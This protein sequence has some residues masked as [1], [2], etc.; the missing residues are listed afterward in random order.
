MPD[1]HRRRA[2]MHSFEQSPEGSKLPRYAIYDLLH[3]PL[4]E[5]P[6]TP[7]S[8]SLFW[9]D[10]QPQLRSCR[11]SSDMRGLALRSS[12]TNRMRTC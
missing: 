12:P 5:H 2:I 8:D 11:T 10:Y 6:C 1:V 4:E 7:A 3:D 9:V